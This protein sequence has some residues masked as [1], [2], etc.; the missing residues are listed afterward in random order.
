MYV[1]VRIT[2][3]RSSGKELTIRGKQFLIGRSEECNLR[4][5]SDTISRKHCV[6]EINETSATIQDLGSRNGTL[7][8]QDRADQPIPLK[9]GDALRIGALELLVLECPAAAATPTPTPKVAA[10]LP[11]RKES[12]MTGDSGVISDWLLEADEE[13]KIRESTA[14][15]DT[16]QYKFEET[17]RIALDQASRETVTHESL[18]VARSDQ[19]EPVD[20]K[21]KREP[22]KLPKIPPAED[23]PKDTQEAAAQMLR[24]FFKRS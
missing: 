14:E 1:K 10:T 3:G 15:L 16:R 11:R 21:K 23:A 24:K 13:A 22:G 17:D 9:I 5:Q 4:P 18:P 7:V 2:S 19:P 8:N 12:R 20:K 6:I